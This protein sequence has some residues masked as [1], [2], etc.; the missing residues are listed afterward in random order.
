MMRGGVQ[1][2]PFELMVLE[3]ALDIVTETFKEQFNILR[4][5]VDKLLY[6][7]DPNEADKTTRKIVAF[8]KP[9]AIFGNRVDTV[10]QVIESTKHK[11]TL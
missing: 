11:T 10:K 4:Y 6:E 8:K 9:I 5:V 7:T 3:T 2:T 1:H